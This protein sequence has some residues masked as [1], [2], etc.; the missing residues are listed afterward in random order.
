SQT[1]AFT[2]DYH[3]YPAKFIPQIVRK[4]IEDYAP[5]KE[6]IVCDPFGGCGTTLV[7]AKLLGHS[8]IGFD[9]NPV[10][11]LITETKTTAINP[12]TLVN[13][14]NKFLEFYEATPKISYSHHSRISYW[15]D[16]EAIIE[17]DRI[18]FAIKK[19][20]NHNVRRFFLCAFSH[21]LKNCSR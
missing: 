6:Q 19:I 4:L 13:Y 11:K 17:L 21:N 8:S 20:N 16:D 12:R 15:F 3:R 7:E 10:A 18:Y 14:K 5:N 9:I 2:H 1:T